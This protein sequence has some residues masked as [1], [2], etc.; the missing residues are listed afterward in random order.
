[1]AIAFPQTETLIIATRESELAMWQARHVQ[2]ALEA[3]Y[4][5]LHVQLLGMTTQGDQVLDKTLNKIG[6]KGLFVKELEQALLD[7]KAHLAVHSVKDIPM[8]L[9]DEFRLAAILDREDPR[10][11]IVGHIKS[12]SELEKGSIVGTSSLRRQS[13]I[14]AR[15][16]KLK[17]VPLRGNLQTR[18]RKLDAGDFDVIVLAA[19]G[20][21]RLNLAHRISALLPVSE[22]LPALGQGALGIECLDERKDILDL[23]KPLNHSIT[24]TCVRAERAM[25]ARLNASCQVP[26]GGYAERHGESISL[27]G[28]VARPDGSLVITSEA[29]GEAKEPEALGIALAERLIDQGAMAILSKLEL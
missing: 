20:L 6:G 19:A 1:M 23:L 9:P 5:G 29:R 7:G 14:L 24:E 18:L 2:Q 10:D 4:P 8:Q 3:Y 12:L 15:Y 22:N 17:I 21:R 26:L 11:A 28:F 25:G 16:P 13:Q 27:K